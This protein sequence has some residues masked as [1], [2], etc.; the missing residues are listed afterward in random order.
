MYAVT[1]AWLPNSAAFFVSHVESSKYT[2]FQS[3]ATASA[4]FHTFQL[5]YSAW[6]GRYEEKDV[7]VTE[8]A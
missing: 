8:G 3:S 7:V 2:F 1:L 6:K 4:L 5:S